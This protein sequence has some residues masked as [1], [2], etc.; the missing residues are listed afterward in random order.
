MNSSP[1]AITLSLL[2]QPQSVFRI[3]DIAMLTGI[4]DAMSIAQ[5]MAYALKKGLLTSPRK[6]IY[7]KNN[8]PPLELACRLY[9]PS[10]V[11]LEYIL[12]REGVIFQYG[13]EITMVSYLSREVEIDGNTFIYRKLK[14][15]VLINMDGIS[16][17]ITYEATKERA[18]LDMLYLN[19][20][21]HFDNPGI[22]D[23]ERVIEL[24]SIYKSRSLT[25]RAI[26]ILDHV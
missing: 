24:T 4:T 16:R 3:P 6:G 20:N 22:L 14:N 18:F 15:D 5:R 21:C 19:G 17:G 1:N 26:K 12:Q 8:Y 13:S 2:Q 7:A 9:T 11:S 23:K 25:E 10:Y